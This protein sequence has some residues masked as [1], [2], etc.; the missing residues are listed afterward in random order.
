MRGVAFLT[1]ALFLGV[2]ILVM[3]GEVDGAVV[4][5]I[6]LPGLLTLMVLLALLSG[7]D[8]LVN[9]VSASALEEASDN[10]V[11]DPPNVAALGLYFACVVLAGMGLMFYFRN[12]PIVADLIAY[13]FSGRRPGFLLIVFPLMLLLAYAKWIDDRSRD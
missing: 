12:H 7:V 2:P 9:H 10:P 8:R 11:S 5:E 6:A 13:D 3:S 1:T 4:A